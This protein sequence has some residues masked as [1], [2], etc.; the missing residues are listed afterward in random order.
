MNTGNGTIRIVTDSTCDIPPALAQEHKIEVIRNVMVID[1][2]RFEDGKGLTREEFYDRLPT[3]KNLPT[4]GTASSGVYEQLYRRLIQEGAEHI[5]SIHASSKL[6]GIINATHAAAQAFKGRVHVIDSFSITL[7]LGF[8][9]LLVA[10]AIKHGARLE[11]ALALLRSLQPRAKVIAMLDT[12][13][14]VRRSGRVSW[15]RAR[16]GNLLRI[17]PF[18]EVTE[19]EVRSLGEVRTRRKGIDRMHELLVEQGPLQRLAILHTNAEGDAR[20]FLASLEMALPASPLVVN[21]TTV[22]GTHV[23]PN[24]LGFAAIVKG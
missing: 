11:E 20:Q 22:V 21:I 7:G 14:Y 17:K 12:L 24:A 13:E 6:S 4:T 15:A 23:G 18:V 9:V 10:E 1:G 2:K 19:G 16:L 5:L 3:M 8:Q